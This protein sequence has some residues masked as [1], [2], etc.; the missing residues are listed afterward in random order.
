[1][2]SSFFEVE[3][4]K[5]IFKMRVSDGEIVYYIP[6]RR[7]NGFFVATDIFGA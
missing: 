6:P 7:A 3:D 1:L 4:R 5:L 2:D